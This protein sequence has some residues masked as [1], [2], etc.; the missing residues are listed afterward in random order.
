MTETVVPHRGHD[1]K[2]HQ[3]MAFG[4]KDRPEKLN[5]VLIHS[6]S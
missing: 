6:G 3:P 4:W 5:I 1:V 2:T